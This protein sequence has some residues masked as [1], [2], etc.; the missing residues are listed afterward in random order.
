MISEHPTA[1]E[2]IVNTFQSQQMPNVNQETQSWILMEILG[3]IPEEVYAFFSI[4]QFALLI[5]NFS[6]FL[7]CITDKCYVY[8]R[9]TGHHSK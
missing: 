3:A 1:I 7:L 9:A 8:V 2:D 4:F 5:P 6:F